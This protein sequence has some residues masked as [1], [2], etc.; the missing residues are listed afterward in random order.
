[1]NRINVQ[2][3]AQADAEEAAVWY[4]AQRPGLGMEFILELDAAL[5]RAAESP[6]AYARQHLETKRPQ[7][8]FPRAS[9]ACGAVVVEPKS[10]D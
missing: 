4:E 10:R 5:E 1:L 8:R 6:V 9:A 3:Q 7:A 2:P